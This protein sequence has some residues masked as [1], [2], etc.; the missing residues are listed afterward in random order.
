MRDLRTFAAA[1][2]ALLTLAVTAHAARSG[3]STCP[4]RVASSAYTSSVQ[5][6]VNAG[7][8]LWGNAL[9]HAR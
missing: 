6:A 9:L 8:D 3:T 4:T 7:T 2:V 5:Q 1:A